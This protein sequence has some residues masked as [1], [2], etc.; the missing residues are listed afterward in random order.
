VH[1]C[2][3][4]AWNDRP[5]EGFRCS[6]IVPDSQDR[7]RTHGNAF[8][9]RGRIAIRLWTDS[10]Q[11]T[12]ENGSWQPFQPSPAPPI[13]AHAPAGTLTVKLRQASPRHSFVLAAPDDATSHEQLS[14]LRCPMCA[15]AAL[16]PALNGQRAS[17]NA[18]RVHA[19]EGGRRPLCARAASPFVSAR[20]TDNSQ[21]KTGAARAAAEPVQGIPENRVCAKTARN[22]T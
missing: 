17:H 10:G 11:L 2:S 13:C 18:Q 1:L 21:R 14:V 4:A 15:E 7:Q 19:F 9:R 6:T 3:A 20:T 16:N 8:L 22:M 12:T 5:H